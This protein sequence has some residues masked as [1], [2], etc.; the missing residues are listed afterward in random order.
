MALA[1]PLYHTLGS[2]NLIGVAV[3]KLTGT[4]TDENGAGMPGVTIAKKGTSSGAN[5]DVNGKYAIDVNPGDVLIF[6]FVGYKTQEVKVANQSVLNI[7]LAVDAKSL[8][9]IVV[10]GFGNQK[11]KDFLGSSTSIKAATIQEMPV[12][13]VES[14][15]QGRM[16]WVQASQVLVYPFVFEE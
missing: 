10:T 11:K 7:Q 3:S 16:T 1:M 15:M 2:T 8:E 13:S 9:E 6:S 5:S 4:I 12:V 14:A